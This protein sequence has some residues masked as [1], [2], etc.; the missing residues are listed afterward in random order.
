MRRSIRK[1]GKPR[2]RLGPYPVD[3]QIC[4]QRGV[5]GIRYLLVAVHGQLPAEIVIEVLQVAGIVRYADR[6]RVARPAKVPLA[7]HRRRVVLRLRITGEVAL[8]GL[9]H[10]VEPAGRAGHAVIDT[11]TS[12]QQ[13]R[14]RACTT[15]RGPEVLEDQAL[16]REL[17]EGGRDRRIQAVRILRRCIDAQVVRNDQQDI[18]LF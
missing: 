3:R 10:R 16:G 8:Q 15:W 9:E 4:N 14:T 7:E 2:P 18:R 17:I 1:P 11:V 6:C 5:I 13:R 12:G